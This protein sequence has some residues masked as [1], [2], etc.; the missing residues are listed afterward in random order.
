MIAW[1]RRLTQQVGGEGAVSPHL[2]LPVELPQ[3]PPGEGVQLQVQGPQLSPQVGG[4][5]SHVRVV[6]EQAPSPRL[7]K[8]SEP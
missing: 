7:A 4:H 1:C 5:R 3:A 8:V 6:G 2:P